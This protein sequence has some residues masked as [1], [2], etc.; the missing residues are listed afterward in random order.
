MP[1]DLGG[2]CDDGVLPLVEGSDEHATVANLIAQSTSGPFYRECWKACPC[3][4]P[5]CE[6]GEDFR[7][8]IAPPIASFFPRDTRVG[9]NHGIAGAVKDGARRKGRGRRCGRRRGQ[10][11]RPSLS[12]SGQSAGTACGRGYRGAWRRCGAPVN[13]Q[14]RGVLTAEGGSP[15]GCAPPRPVGRGC[16]RGRGL[17][18]KFLWDFQA[19]RKFFQGFGEKSAVVQVSDQRQAGQSEVHLPVLT[20]RLDR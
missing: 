14:V 7:W 19:G 11:C 10:H 12:C 2:D 16:A 17:I 1:N 3:K 8:W 6:D 4:C 9:G 20:L 18:E 13:R 15:E 5:Q